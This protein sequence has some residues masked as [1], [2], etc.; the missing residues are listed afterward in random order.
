MNTDGLEGSAERY[1]SPRR[2]G[3]NMSI[4]IESNDS[5]IK[6]NTN[7]ESKNKVVD[8]NANTS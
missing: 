2:D 4:N 1:I 3:V 6:E 8:S 7:S 5:I